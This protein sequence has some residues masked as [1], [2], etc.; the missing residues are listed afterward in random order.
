MS[1][2][3]EADVALSVRHPMM[4]K[5]LA[6]KV[7]EYGAAGC[8]VILNRTALYEELLGADYPL[9]A[10]DPGEILAALKQ[11]ARNPI[12][13][14]RRPIAARRPR[15]STRSSASPSN[16]RRRFSSGKCGLTKPAR[17]LPSG[18]RQAHP[19]PVRRCRVERLAAEKEA[20]DDKVFALTHRVATL[21]AAN[22]T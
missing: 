19:E 2:C 16:S 9:F 15:A 4:D 10:T 1:C 13:V 14:R 3:G 7:L 5:E 20:S 22:A 11:I 8:A 18:D 21:E 6:T 17:A 12:F